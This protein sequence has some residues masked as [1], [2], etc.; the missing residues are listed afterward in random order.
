V[1]PW[2]WTAAFID[3]PSV[4]STKATASQT[5]GV[6]PGQLSGLLEPCVRLVYHSELEFLSSSSTVAAKYMPSI[7]VVIELS[8]DA[9]LSHYEGFA[10]RVYTWSLDGRRVVFPAQALRQVVSPDGVHGVFRLRFSASG[11]FESIER[12]R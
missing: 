2:G 3:E 8:A 7:D 4:G 10:E 11:Q 9:C 1:K 6:D 5:L 12:L